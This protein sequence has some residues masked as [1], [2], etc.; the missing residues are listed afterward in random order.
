MREWLCEQRF[1]A[2]FGIVDLPGQTAGGSETGIGQKIDVMDVGDDS[3]DNDRR[4]FGTGEFVD[5][6]VADEIM[7]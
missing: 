6:D 3:I 1:A 7:Q 2:P 4:W 5:D